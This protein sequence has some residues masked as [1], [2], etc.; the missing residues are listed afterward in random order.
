VS[1]RVAGSVEAVLVN[2]NQMVAEGEVLVRLDTRDHSAALEQARA[3]VA[4]AQ[5]QY[6]AAAV[7]IPL[8]D[9]SVRSQVQ[10]VRSALTGAA[11]GELKQ[12]RMERQ[13]MERLVQNRIVAQEDF[14]RADAAFQQAQA[15]VGG[16]QASLRQAQGRRREVDVRQAE[17][18]TAAGRLAEALARQ[19][20][21]EQLLEYTA[22][23]APFPG[24]VTRKNVEIGQIVS[25][26][27]PLMAVVST[28]DVWVVANFKENQ[29]AGVQPGHPVSI[30]VDMYPDLH[31]RGWVDSIQA[32]TGSRFA[33]LPVENASGNFVKVV[34]RI[35]VKIVLEK[36]QLQR[37][38][39]FPGLSVVP[40]I[41]L[42]ARPAPAAVPRPA[43]SDSRA[44]P[45]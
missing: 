18:K 37:R 29:L 17:M 45:R 16:I 14:D 20:Q 26:G 35:P 27:Q 36:T 3:A 38:P 34:Q 43:V 5:G 23:R 30:E 33:L 22:L 4:I 12:A 44:R 40:T 42:G 9:H 28:D 2:D 41:D 13:R 24:R 19:R 10:E 6:D 31:L 8:V 25:V 32:G 15:K 11:D 7:G 1:A 39:L 21:A